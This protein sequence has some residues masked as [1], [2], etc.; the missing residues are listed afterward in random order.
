MQNARNFTHTPTSDELL[1][2][3]RKKIPSFLSGKRLNHTFFVEK[4][5]NT[6]AESVFLVYNISDRYLND[7][8]AAA[9]LHDITK[10]ISLSEQLTL[11][12]KYAIA[13]GG[14]PSNAILHG[15]TAAHLARELFGINDVVFSAVYKHTTGSENMNIIDKI[16]FLA[17]YIEP[18]RTHE[19]CIKTGEFFRKS[20]SCGTDPENAL[21]TACVMSIDGTLSHLISS[22]EFIDVQ[23]VLA[24]NYLLKGLNNVQKQ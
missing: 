6:I 15:K 8:S 18:S 2:Q 7:V 10:Q 24:R 1:S 21:D 19:H 16:I 14:N 22:G 17:D 5:A 11:C 13:P 20:L 9:L 12:E 4:E 23:T 3:I